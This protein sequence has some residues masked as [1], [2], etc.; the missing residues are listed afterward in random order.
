M[1]SITVT[2][3]GHYLDISPAEHVM[4]GAGGDKGRAPLP[5]WAERRSVAFHQHRP[6]GLKKFGKDSISHFFFSLHGGRGKRNF[7][8]WL[9]FLFNCL[10]SLLG[11]RNGIKPQMFHSQSLRKD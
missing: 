11:K 6:L 2:S 10:V 3:R 1:M 5:Q 9:L 7:H 8:C 4:W